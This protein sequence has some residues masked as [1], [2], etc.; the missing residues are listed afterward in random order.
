MER[1]PPSSMDDLTEFDLESLFLSYVILKH[2]LSE[3]DCLQ[4]SYFS[5]SY[6]SMEAGRHRRFQ[7]TKA[8][9]HA[10]IN[11]SCLVFS[12]KKIVFQSLFNFFF[13]FLLL[14]YLSVNSL[15]LNIGISLIPIY[16]ILNVSIL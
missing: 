14:L 6:Y 11:F 3:D 4:F 1:F 9:Y 13:F 7:S 2:I 8:P 12:E 5:L 15:C 16:L 10:M